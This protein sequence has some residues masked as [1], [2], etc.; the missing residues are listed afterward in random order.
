MQSSKGTFV[1]YQQV[2]TLTDNKSKFYKI[3]KLFKDWRFWMISAPTVI[4]LKSI[5][6]SLII[7]WKHMHS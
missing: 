4:T 2:I 1:L 3:N 7:T 5:V 6:E